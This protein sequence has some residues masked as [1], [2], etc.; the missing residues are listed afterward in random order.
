M[1]KK[2]S[3]FDWT[4]EST[5]AFEALKDAL[6]SA[7]LLKSPDPNLDYEMSTDASGFAIG[8]VLSQDQG[9][10]MRPIAFHSRKLNKAETKHPIH[11]AEMLAIMEALKVFR[12]W[13]FCKYFHRSPQPAFL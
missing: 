4:E 6:S 9:D 12:P 13:S 10:G 2:D 7:S 5:K 1:L 8:A 3:L 11:D